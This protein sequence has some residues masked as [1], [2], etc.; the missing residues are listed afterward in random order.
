MTCR[1][2]PGDGGWLGHQRDCATCSDI[3]AHRLAMA[4]TLSLC[5][6]GRAPARQD[7]AV[8]GAASASGDAPEGDRED[9]ARSA[10]QCHPLE[11]VH[12]G[13]SCGDFA[14]ERRAE[15]GLKPHLTRGFKV[16]NDPKFGKRPV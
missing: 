16:S 2:R 8:A 12:D 1:D 5:R 14:I 15:A 6:C 9:R 10:A 4:G 11:P 7:P 3:Q 13:R